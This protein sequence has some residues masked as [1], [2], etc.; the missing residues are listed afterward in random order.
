VN[1]VWQTAN[2]FDKFPHI[3]IGQISLRQNVG[4][5]EWGMFYQTLCASDFFLGTKGW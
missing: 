4:E 2:K 3:F 5:I 1:A